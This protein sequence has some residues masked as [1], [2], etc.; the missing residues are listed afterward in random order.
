VCECADDR[1]RQERDQ[2]TEDEATGR[3]IAEHAGGNLPN[4]E[5]INRQQ[6]ED[7]AEL[8]QHGEGLAEVVIVEAEKALDQEEVAGRGDR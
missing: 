6:R 5:K 8:D 3:R 1:G 7:S 4:T 2:H